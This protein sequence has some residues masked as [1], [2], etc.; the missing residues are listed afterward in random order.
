M[1]FKSPVATL[2]RIF[3]TVF[4]S[5]EIEHVFVEVRKLRLLIIRSDLNCD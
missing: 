2:H 3:K 4:I 1:I 5:F